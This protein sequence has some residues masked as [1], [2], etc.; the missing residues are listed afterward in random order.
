MPDNAWTVTSQTKRLVYG[1][2]GL[3]D[4]YRIAFTTGNGV[5][6][7]IDVPQSQYSAANVAKLIAAQVAQHDAIAKGS[8]GP[9]AS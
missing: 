2:Q 1:P 6:D 7:H 3:T 5:K 9:V 4:G 8:A